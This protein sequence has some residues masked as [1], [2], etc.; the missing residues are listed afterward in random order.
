MEPLAAPGMH[1]MPTWSVVVHCAGQKYNRSTAAM[2]SHTMRTGASVLSEVS[3][4]FCTSKEELFETPSRE[5]SLRGV[6]DLD[7][8]GKPTHDTP[9][10]VVSPSKAEDPA[11]AR[12]KGV[13]PEH[14]LDEVHDE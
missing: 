12:A 5:K 3:Y 13:L 8:D 7:C 11:D 6:L 10:Q 4:T 14:V 9:W 2:E 1:E